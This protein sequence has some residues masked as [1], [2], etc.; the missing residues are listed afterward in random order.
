MRTH[1]RPSGIAHWHR[2][3]RIQETPT[4]KRT[5]NRGPRY[6]QIDQGWRGLRSLFVQ[7][8]A[9]MSHSATN[10]PHSTQYGRG[11]LMRR[12][13][14]YQSNHSIGQH[15]SPSAIVDVQVGKNCLNMLKISHPNRDWSSL[16]FLD[17]SSGNFQATIAL[18]QRELPF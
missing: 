6:A 5:Q 1:Q 2:L 16:L 18:F 14:V 10:Q 4:I 9:Y 13:S 7:A 15:T 17:S 11:K 8:L 12:L 3:L